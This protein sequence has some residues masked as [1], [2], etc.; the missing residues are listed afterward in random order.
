MMSAW[1]YLQILG[2]NLLRCKNFMIKPKAL[3]M[4]IFFVFVIV[5]LFFIYLFSAQWTVRIHGMSV[6]IDTFA[7]ISCDSLIDDYSEEYDVILNE[8]RRRRFDI[9]IINPISKM[10]VL[11]EINRKK[12]EIKFMRNTGMD[13]RLVID[14]TYK[15]EMIKYCFS[16]GFQEI[17]GRVYKVSP[18]F[19][20]FLE[21]TSSP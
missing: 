1:Q 18:Y 9:K 11:Y 2:A 8:K 13:A 21:R 12:S 4:K 10:I 6:N 17:D 5:F 19:S 14:I 20:D 3:I 15:D 16:S 7:S